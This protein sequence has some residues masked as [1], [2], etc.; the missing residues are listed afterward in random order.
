MSSTPIVMRLFRGL[1][2]LVLV[3]IMLIELLFPSPSSEGPAADNK[4]TASHPLHDADGKEVF[5]KEDKATIDHTTVSWTPPQ[6]LQLPDWSKQL[7]ATNF[8]P[9]VL[10]L[11]TTLNRDG[12][13]PRMCPF[14]YDFIAHP[15][16]TEVRCRVK[17]ETL[18]CNWLTLLFQNR[19]IPYNMSGL[20]LNTADSFTPMPHESCLGNSSP[21]GKFCVVNKEDISRHLQLLAPHRK[22]KQPQFMGWDYKDDVPWQNRSALPVFRG[23]PRGYNVDWY[24][25]ANPN[26]TYAQVLN[27]L[28]GRYYVVDYSMEH[29]ELLN[30]R[31]S[32]VPTSGC[33]SYKESHGLTKLLPTDSI[34]GELYYSQY[35]VAL[36]LG[37]AGAAYRSSR[38]LMTRTAVVLQDFTYEEWFTHY[39]IPWVHY[40]PLQENLGN[41]EETLVWIQQ[42]PAQVQTI[43][44]NG[45]KFYETYL[46]FP[47][48]AE[49]IYELVYR[50][51]EYDHYNE[52]HQ[53]HNGSN[54]V[55]TP[56]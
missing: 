14:A 37:G 27:V 8:T 6:P 31:F 19:T 25:K 11:V 53:Q 18:W 47:G 54:V 15:D 13:Q 38:H 51:S 45:R 48:N 21:K 12:S 9:H 5:L 2:L 17:A 33:W 42:H 22:P 3:Q 26:A 1:A 10:E 46:T 34:K 36:V 7:P 16:H 4:A 30:A 41:L 20:I 23:S 28:M 56:S 32:A 49:H 29:P 40:I 24:C 55:I 43:G 50:L 44:E 52:Q 35:Q 39:M